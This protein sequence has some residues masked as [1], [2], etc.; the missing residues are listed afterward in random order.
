MSSVTKIAKNVRTAQTVVKN[1]Q[2]AYRVYQ[3]HN[4]SPAMQTGAKVAIVLGSVLLG[5]VVLTAAVLI[6][7]S[8]A[9]VA[10][11]S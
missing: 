8:F 11:F 4:G 6:L 5:S 2:A 1:G 10:R 9:L 7:S 3:K